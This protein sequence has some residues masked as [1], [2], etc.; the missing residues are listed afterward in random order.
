MERV[1][2]A[3]GE[4]TYEIDVDGKTIRILTRS[5]DDQIARLFD[6]RDATSW[7]DDSPLS[8][9]D[10]VAVVRRLFESETGRREA[11]EV[12]GV[13]P[14]AAS[15]FPDDRRISV[16]KVRPTSFSL[17]G[18]PNGLAFEMDERGDGHLWALGGIRIPLGSDGMW[19][20]VNQLIDALDNPS[21]AAR[22]PRILVLGTA[23]GGP[24]VQAA[25]ETGD[26]GVGIVWRMLDSGV[27]GDVVAV[28]EL[29][30]ERV[31][32]WLSML[33]PFRD[34]LVAERVHRQRLRPA[35]TA[36]RWARALERWSS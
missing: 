7:C 8:D 28:S 31:D 16:S 11:I 25:V 32:G 27:V 9:E 36:E 3:A 29:T 21:R 4:E 15:S 13:A 10:V 6:L 33:R 18:R 5:S 22:W 17:P 2:L 30:Y 24:A 20:I 26:W 34:R 23:L 35:R 19:W 12:V 14:G 1:A